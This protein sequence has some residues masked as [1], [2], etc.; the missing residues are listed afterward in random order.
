MPGRKPEREAK[1]FCGH[2]IWHS[3]LRGKV[4]AFAEKMPAEGVISYGR[5]INKGLAELPAYHPPR[6]KFMREK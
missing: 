5:G 3:C 6:R 4:D 1:R 2:S